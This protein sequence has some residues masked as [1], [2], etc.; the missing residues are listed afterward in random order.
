MKQDEPVTIPVDALKPTPVENRHPDYKVNKYFF[1]AIIILFGI[2]LFFN[3]IE[4]FSAFLGAIMFYVLSKPSM[5][6]L[7]KKRK[8]KKSRAAAL[9]ITVSFFIILVPIL[10]LLALLYEKIKIFVQ[11]PNFIQHTL[12]EVDRKIQAQYH[13][14]IF[15]AKT[16]ANI[17]TSANNALSALIN[18]GV[19]FFFAIV[20]MYF[21]LYFM[22]IKMNR[23]EAAIVFFLPFKRNKI[24]MFGKD[25]VA[26][27]FS[28][29][30]GV[31]LI[32][33]VQGLL[34]YFAYIIAGLP[35]P[36]FWG[37]ITAFVSIV[38]IVGTAIVWVPAAVYLLINGSSWQGIFVLLWGALVLGL[39]DNVIRFLLAKKMAQIHEVVTVLGVIIGLKSFGIPG[40]I[41]GPLLISYFIIL[42]KI[43]YLEY[44]NT[45]PVK[46]K[47]S[48]PIR[49]N[50]PFL[51]RPAKRR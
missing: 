34:A 20:M 48:I 17:Q 36:G 24:E 16:I 13:M 21:F 44:Q 25:L 19:N 10:F 22:L 46:K 11:D 30:V 3:L 12:N 45:E 1:L 50:L 6:Y 2:Y 35:E 29:A 14:K 18:K 43:Y 32:A 39:V 7:V 4:F 15:S 9:V 49:F 28:N 47:K 8:W 26:L 37:I 31:P 51:G 23:M 33:V 41:F 5:E 40:L 27:T 38:P 42:L